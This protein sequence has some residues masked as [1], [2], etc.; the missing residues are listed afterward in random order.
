[1]TINRRQLLASSI[2]APFASLPSL[3]SAADLCS[4]PQAWDKTYDVIVIGS[5]GAGLSAG[6]VA[7]EKGANT[8]VL[9]KLPFPG[10]N[11]M[12]S[13]GGL[14]AA[15]EADYKKAGVK[16]SPQLHTEQT[17]AAGD[18]RADPELVKTLCEKVPESV[19]WLNRVGPVITRPSHTT[20]HAVRHQGGSSK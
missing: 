10:G 13:G 18:N 4:V 19:E 9:E 11:T 2:I 7:K 8:V 5:G 1:M 3:A 20:W 6:I 16:D 12:V 17:L 14:N 15:I